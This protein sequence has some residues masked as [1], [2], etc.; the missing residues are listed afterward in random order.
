MGVGVGVGLALDQRAGPALSRSLA[1]AMLTPPPASPML[2]G[3]MSRAH[4][5]PHLRCAW[6]AG[7]AGGAGNGWKVFVGPGGADSL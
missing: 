5:G 7:I 2:A 6:E 1:R 3:H 4:A